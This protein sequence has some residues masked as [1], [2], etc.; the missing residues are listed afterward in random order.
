M[1]KA[2]GC[3]EGRVGRQF[4]RGTT[5]VGRIWYWQARSIASIC[6]GSRETAG[7]QANGFEVTGSETGA[8]KALKARAIWN[9]RRLSEKR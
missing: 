1:E 7:S 3:I 5:C 9:A 6:T 4:I 2:H 8:G